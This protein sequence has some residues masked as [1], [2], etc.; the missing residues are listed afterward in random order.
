[1]PP[2][3]TENLKAKGEMSDQH[4]SDACQSQQRWHRIGVGANWDFLR[5]GF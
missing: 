3:Y 1:M 4:I 5:P 2:K